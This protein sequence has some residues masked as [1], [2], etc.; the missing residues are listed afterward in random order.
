MRSRFIS[1]GTLLTLLSRVIIGHIVE[2]ILT[3]S[4]S[5]CLLGGI[6]QVVLREAWVMEC[7]AIVHI[8]L[9]LVFN[10]PMTLPSSVV[11]APREPGQIVVIEEGEYAE[12]AHSHF[13]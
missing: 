9:H 5:R 13:V 1:Y 10:A 4:V 12:L 2:L 11:L 3:G 7:E 6:D 8:L